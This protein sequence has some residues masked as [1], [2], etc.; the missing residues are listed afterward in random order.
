[1]NQATRLTHLLLLV[2]LSGLLVWFDLGAL[3]LTD[4]DEGS[5]AEAAR[6][7]VETGDWISPTLNYQPRFAKPVLIYWLMS[8]AYVIFGES[9]F[10]ARLPSAL[11]GTGLI[12]LQYLFLARLRGHTVG[13]FGA[14]ILLLNLE[15]V[16][17]SRMA[18]TD[19]VLVFFMTLALYGFWLGLHGEGRSRHAI[20]CLYVGMALGTL[21]KG[22]VGVVVPLLVIV[23]YLTFSRRWGEFWRH[24]RPVGGLVVFLLL[25]TPWYAAMLAR[26]GSSYLA[27]AQAETVGR[28]VSTIGG[29]SGTPL[30]YVPVLLFGLFPWSGFLIVGLYQA[31]R[32]MRQ[33]GTDATK[34]TEATRTSHL[35]LETFAA[36]WVMAV[37]TFFS[38]SATRLP[39][40][41][42]PLFPAAAILASSFWHRCLLNPS[43]PGRR[44]AIHITVALGYLLA[45]TLAAVPW[46]YEQFRDV[47]A[48]EFPAA[49]HITPGTG[50]VAMGVALAIGS[51]LIG[52]FGLSEHRRAGTFWAAGATIAIV[53]LLA[54]RLVLPRFDAYFVS[55]PHELA[56]A[57]GVNLGPDERLILYGPPRPS[58]IFYAKRRAIVIRPGEEAAM[59]PYL[60]GPGRTM[61]LLPTRMKSR[62]PQ[63]AGSFV[64]L[65]EHH[66]YSLL[67]SEPIVKVPEILPPP[68]ASDP[69][70]DPHVRYKR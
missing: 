22:P 36:I 9:E 26:H 23:P 68:A 33:R 43:T 39:H 54:I 27:S 24:G 60:M 51:G 37:F 57:A 65:L 48:Q 69:T 47:I 2:A 38:L 30:F 32:A 29:H 58:L 11:F 64:T 41:I 42:A 40:Y 49:T 35:E 59:R 21:T 66:G 52:Y 12:L 46:L 25:A 3:D 70:T 7:M 15:I 50:P 16:A 18:L 34:S 6:E 45:I 62:L 56:Y 17:I 63:E 4:R 20:W 53:M 55:P 13:L 61:I 31:I 5:N 10:A 8:A 14:S 28:F 67:G 1:M 19:S 44:A